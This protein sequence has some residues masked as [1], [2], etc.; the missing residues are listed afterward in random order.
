MSVYLPAGYRF[1]PSRYLSGIGYAGLD[2]ALTERSPLERKAIRSATFIVAASPLARRTIHDRAR[3]NGGSETMPVVMGTFR[4]L[5]TNGDLIYGFSFGGRLEVTDRGDFSICRLESDAPVFA[6]EGGLDSPDVFL[7]AELE[8][9]LARRRAA[10]ARDDAGFARRILG[11][12]PR[13]LF[14]ATLATL[15]R[16]LASLTWA[17]DEFRTGAR[18]IA[19]AIAVLRAAGEWAEPMPELAD[20]L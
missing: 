19:R 12:P 6:M 3:P 20:V 16:H 8:A 15:R 18:Q 2:I 9:A 11:T 4:L 10:W 1:R 13:D 7:F 14:R 17:G 5:A